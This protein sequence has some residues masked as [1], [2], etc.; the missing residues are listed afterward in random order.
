[1]EIIKTSG[2]KTKE[3]DD[4]DSEDSELKDFQRPSSSKGVPPKLKKAKLKKTKVDKTDDW[5]SGK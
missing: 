5:D 2:K 4:W 3:N 1:M